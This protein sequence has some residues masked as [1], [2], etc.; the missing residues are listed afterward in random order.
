[1]FWV[2][3]A[4]TIAVHT[5]TYF[6][7]GFAAF[8][9]FNYTATLA[10]KDNN[11]RPATDPLVRAGVLFQP[12]RGLLFGI[13]FYF[14]RDILFHPGNG[15][16]IMWVML[17]FVG[18][19]STFAPAPTSIEGFIYTKPSSRRNWGGLVEILIQSLLLSIIT[20]Y[21]VVYPEN[22]WLD[23]HLGRVVRRCDDSLSIR[24]IAEKVQST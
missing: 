10:Q 4:K 6:G 3:I 23:W 8:K 21:W 24:V 7:V 19:L 9:V 17:V 13:V 11:F 2:I 12:L 14:F 20:H 16:L 15:W 22:T 18:I 1:M 5:L